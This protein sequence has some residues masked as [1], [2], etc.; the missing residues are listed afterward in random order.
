M[1]RLLHI[2]VPVL[3]PLFAAAQVDLEQYKPKNAVIP[4][5]TDRAKVMR[6]APYLQEPVDGGMT[7]MWTTSVPCRSWVE[8]G[9]DSTNMRVAR[10]LDE[11]VTPV[12]T[13]HKIRLD[14]L[15]QGS[16]Y[17][18]RAC[19]QEVLYYS[20]YYKALG[21]T[22]RTAAASF[23]AWDS[24]DT[25]FTAVIFN[26]LHRRFATYDMF[27]EQIETKPDFVVFNG[28]CFNDLETETQIV[29]T[30]ARYGDG[31]GASDIP[32]IY[33]RGNHEIR[34]AGSLI[35]KN[36]IAL[37][38]GKFYGAFSFGDT[39]FVILDNGEDKPD[40]SPIYYGM[41][42]FSTYREAQTEFLKH[43][44]SSPEFLN[45]SRRVLI[46]H[47]PIYG[48]V[49]GKYNPC[50]PLWHPVLAAAPFDVALN[51]H[52]HRYR[53]VPKNEDGNNFPVVI[54]GGNTPDKATM[55]ILEKRGRKLSLRV[56]DAEGRLLLDLK[57]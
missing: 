46:H 30:L 29:E 7:V 40:D 5:A 43:E 49:K 32:G 35:L 11:G 9:T 14:G 31:F 26:D 4:P 36:H 6:T 21:D 8:Y 20:A 28:D 2:L 25:D 38:G 18:Y 37:P 57:L 17:Y 50:H 53:Y 23:R 19:S 42:D 55:M 34:G 39:R 48:R 47:I 13:I 51:G 1:R 27:T 3:L 33:I 41:N 15:E 10:T 22:V 45:A 44:V 24:A 56:L 16:R 12:G 54:G 52:Q